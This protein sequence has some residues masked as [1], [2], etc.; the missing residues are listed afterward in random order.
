MV[1]P[2]YGTAKVETFP[3]QATSLE[4]RRSTSIK[5]WTKKKR[6]RR[7]IRFP[8]NNVN[9]NV[10]LFQFYK[11]EFYA[12]IDITSEYHESI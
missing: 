11:S 9:K 2:N 7:L 3:F 5:S 1:E 8:P 12:T 10:F 6:S 4:C